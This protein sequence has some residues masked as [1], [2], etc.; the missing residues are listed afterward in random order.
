[1]RHV[2]S[3]QVIDSNLGVYPVLEG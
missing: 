2:K 3:S 1:M